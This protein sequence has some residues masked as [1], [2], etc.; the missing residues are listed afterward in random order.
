MYDA[1]SIAAFDN[2]SRC[3]RGW[4]LMLTAAVPLVPCKEFA[5]SEGCGSW[6]F[7]SC[8]QLLRDVSS[9]LESFVRCATGR[10]CDLVCPSCPL[11]NSDVNVPAMKAW[12]AQDCNRPPEREAGNLSQPRGHCWIARPPAPNWLSS[13]LTARVEM[14]FGQAHGSGTGQ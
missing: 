1:L 7:L 11:L 12:E 4:P 10:I 13:I 8:Q 14:R 6:R 9:S 5:A 3:L 2:I